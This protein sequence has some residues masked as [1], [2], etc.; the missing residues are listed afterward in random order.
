MPSDIGL[1]T[2]ESILQRALD[3]L[4]EGTDKS[5]NTFYYQLASAFAIGGNELMIGAKFIYDAMSVD[6]RTGSDL[7][8]FIGDRCALT[9]T[10]ATR[11]EGEVTFTGTAGAY[12][13]QG[14]LVA[15]GDQQFATL[16]GDTIKESGTDDIKVQAVNI[17]NIG[18]IAAGAI[19]KIVSQTLQVSGVTN[20]EALV[21][22]TDEETDASFRERYKWHLQNF[23]YNLNDSTIKEWAY[24]VAGIG[25]V[26]PK[27][28]KESATIT[29]YALDD[30][31]E[32]AGEDLISELQANLSNRLYYGFTIFATAPAKETV[33][34][35]VKVKTADETLSATI[36]TAIDDALHTYPD[37]SYI[38]TDLSIWE[39]INAV[40]KVAN[41][42]NIVDIKIGDG[43][44]PVYTLSATDGSKL[45]AV[46]DVNVTVA[47]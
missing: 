10:Q 2:Y 11:A 13:A 6:N 42:D 41:M 8:A 46:G 30:G 32:P 23:P 4:P 17:G 47:T 43:S 33:D 26:R 20:A 27:G 29:V 21:S 12:I 44:S 22:G 19:N 35:N 37:P 1:P 9:R 45:L 3:A 38:R 5:E 34:I 14:T 28:D 36:K 31:Y 24:E 16:W 25:Q 7:D 18:Y 39:V 40:E 15:A